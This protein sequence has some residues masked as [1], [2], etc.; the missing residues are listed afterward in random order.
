MLR[1]LLPAALI[2]GF[3]F[4]STALGI[5]INVPFDQPTIQAGIDAAV[6]GDEIIVAPG[7]YNEVINFSD[8]QLEPADKEI[9]LR[10][11]H[12][13]DVTIIDAQG[14]PSSV[15]T[16][17]SGATSSTVI[18]GFTLRN[19]TGT[20]LGVALRG[21]GMLNFMASPAVLNCIFEQNTASF[22]D[23]G[24]VFNF[25]ASP[26][27]A[28]CVFH[29]NTAP[30]GGAIYNDTSF[31]RL[32]NCVITDNS[33]TEGGAAYNFNG[34]APLFL[35]CILWG[36]TATSFGVVF[37]GSGVP[38][39]RYSNI[40]D[41]FLGEGNVDVNP[42]FVNDLTDFHLQAGSPCIDAGDSTSVAETLFVDLDGNA[43]GADDPDTPDTGK[44]VFALVVDMGAYELQGAGCTPSECAG[45]VTGPKGTPDGVVD[46]LDLLAL[47]GTWGTC[48][49]N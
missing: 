27:F 45:D 38:I 47:I 8:G 19:G 31:P 17:E 9:V 48:S 16:C 34:S 18:D 24:A 6:N 7:I 29:D 25:F 1:T 4:T 23:G 40:E 32:D 26:Y 10:S 46:A 15:V 22:G 12:G 11:S 33:A 3:G 14:I 30:E 28:N 41:G 5:V 42:L 39:A 49:P 20:V 37:A 35:N 21:G 36:N 2:C 43:R 44:A 13:A